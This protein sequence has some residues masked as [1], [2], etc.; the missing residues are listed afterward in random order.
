MKLKDIWHEIPIGGWF[1]DEGGFTGIKM[2]M[3]NG[4]WVGHIN[5]TGESLLNPN[6]KLR[7]YGK[8]Q[9]TPIADYNIYTCGEKVKT[10]CS[11]NQYYDILGIKRKVC[12]Q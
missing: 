2:S 6:D 12:G 10:T 1:I 3:G 4:W 8:D 9:N 7:W 11:C 5:L